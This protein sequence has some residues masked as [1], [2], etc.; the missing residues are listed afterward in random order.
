[1]TSDAARS[2]KRM[3]EMA[4]AV[5]EMVLRAGDV[6]VT[7]DGVVSGSWCQG[8]EGVLGMARLRPRPFGVYPG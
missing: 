7:V 5:A 1:M 6:G 3:R 4:R 2:T 8:V